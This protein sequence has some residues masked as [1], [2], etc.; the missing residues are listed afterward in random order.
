MF[1]DLLDVGHNSAHHHISVTI[2]VFSD[3]VNDDIYTEMQRTLKSSI[4]YLKS[5]LL[6][7]NT[8][9]ERYY[10]PPQVYLC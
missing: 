7:E 2:D 5:Q 6:L 3:R 1:V 4:F 8:A 9:K 10:R